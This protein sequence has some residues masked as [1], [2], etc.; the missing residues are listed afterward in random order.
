MKLTHTLAIAAFTDLISAA[1]P[2]IAPR[3]TSGAATVDLSTRTGQARFLGSNFIYGFPDNGVDAQTSIPDH[4]LTDIKFNACRAGGAQ[5]TS[6]GWGSGGYDEYVGR[7][8]ST[9]SN[10]RS[11]R[12]YN[13]AFILLLH[14]L[15][16]ADGGSSVDDLV[17]GDNGDYTEFDTFLDQVKKDVE[18]ND[19][20]DGLVIDIWNEPELDLFWKRTWDQ[21]L[22]YYVH[23]TQLVRDRFPTTLITGPS[24]AHAASVDIENWQTWARI[25]AD[26]QSIPDIYSWHQI[27]PWEREPDRTVADFHTLLTT[28]NLPDRP[29]DLNEYASTEEQNPGTSVF[30]LAQL[31]RH[32]LR[33]LRANWGGGGELHDFLA[34]LVY[35]DG[36]GVYHPNGEWY[37]YRYYGE[38]VG[39]RVA[40][41]AAAD[42]LFDVFATLEEG[43]VKILAGTRSVQAAYDVTVGGLAALGL[44]ADGV[45]GVRTMRFDWSGQFADAGEPVDVGCVEYTAQAGELVL[46]VDPPTNSTAFAFEISLDG[47]C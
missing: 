3:Q 9:L 21:Y 23:A 5:T 1:P 43:G 8:E 15:W 4:F 14:D 36:D 45:I 6:G 25:V 26:T 47:K 30:Y 32:D 12:K 37:V 17:P 16:G 40:T 7:F 35:R 31:E 18:E 44:P 38:M 27:G 46:T 33:G 22:D 42:L 24:F 34:N 2:T 39:E 10:Y 11:T 29:I 41:T 28:Y 13:G 20:L 19:M